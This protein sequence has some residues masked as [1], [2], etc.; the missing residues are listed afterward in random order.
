MSKKDDN[1]TS[2]VRNKEQLKRNTSFLH[3]TC[4][5]LDRFSAITDEMFHLAARTVL[6]SVHCAMRASFDRMFAVGIIKLERVT[7]I[8]PSQ[9]Q[10]M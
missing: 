10:G 4:K 9:S 8:I 3:S 5:L 6:Y 1:F 7:P 2:I